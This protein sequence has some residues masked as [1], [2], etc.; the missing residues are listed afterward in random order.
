MR[1][2]ARGNRTELPTFRFHPDPVATGSVAKQPT[3]CPACDQDRDHVY[4]G[5]FL[6][7]GEVDG[8]CP[9]CIADGSAAARFDGSFQDD[10]AC[11]P[12]RKSASVDELIHRT[13]GY[14]SWQQEEWLS[15][16][17]EFCAYLGRTG[18]RR[19][20]ELSDEL[21]DDVIALNLAEFLDDLPAEPAVAPNQADAEL[22][23]FRCLRCGRHRL[24]LNVS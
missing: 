22:H 18:A 5:P 13:P 9:W 6:S 20:R 11:E 2:W 16:C 7:V 14:S 19:V 23:L 17:G 15:H 1:L 21:R 10:A 24:A 4:V 12:V 8:I 3:R